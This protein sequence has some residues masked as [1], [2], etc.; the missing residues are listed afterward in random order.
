MVVLILPQ[1]T[2]SE[3]DVQ[4]SFW[5]A[6]MGAH[7]FLVRRIDKWLSFMTHISKS[8]LFYA[9]DLPLSCGLCREK[10]LGCH[11]DCVAFLVLSCFIMKLYGC[12]FEE[13]RGGE[14]RIR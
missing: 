7:L 9:A 1:H 10:L 13:G 2:A 6:E 5:P 4:Q 3:G 11:W 12:V 14:E 8:S